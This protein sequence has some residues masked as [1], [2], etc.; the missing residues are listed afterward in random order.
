M[1]TR[2]AALLA[3]MVAIP[4]LVLLAQNPSR[5]AADDPIPPAAIMQSDGDLQHPTPRQECRFLIRDS[6]K[7][8]WTLGVESTGSQ[9]LNS[10]RQA[11]VLG[12]FEGVHWS[13]VERLVDD[14]WVYSPTA[15]ADDKGGLWIAWSEWNQPHQFWII[16][17]LYWDGEKIHPPP[18][19]PRYPVG[20]FTGNEL[21]PTLA[22]ES[23][24]RPIIAYEFGVNH[25]FELH[26][27][28]FDGRQWND[29]TVPS[30]DTFRT[31]AGQLAL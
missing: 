24:G 26:A 19:T 23:N 12:R 31:F 18:G 28:T 15:A 22:I 6:L 4:G 29:E 11:I 2:H 9:Q 13:Q 5:K 17:A 20:P 8:L 25:H 30:L 16:R 21:R 1:P 3:A 10:T 27:S 14:W 7:R